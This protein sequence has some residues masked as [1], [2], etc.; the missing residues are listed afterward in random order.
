MSILVWNVRGLG[1]TRTFQML[2]HYLQHH[3][4][5]VVFLMEALSTHDRLERLRVSFGFSGKLMIDRDGRS[6]SLCLLWTDFVEVD[7]ITYFRHHIDTKIKSPG[8]FVWHFMRFYGY[9]EAV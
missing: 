1:N 2:R 8:G 6:G 9:P 4:P 5:E 3:N 7:L